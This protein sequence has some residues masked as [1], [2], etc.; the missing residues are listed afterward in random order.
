MHAAL[1]LGVEPR[2]ISAIAAGAALPPG[3]RSTGARDAGPDA[4][5]TLMD[6]LRAG[7][8]HVPVAVTFPL[9]RIRDA[10]TAQA[11]RHVH[12]KIVVTTG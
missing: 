1:A 8:L 10:V 2:R 12:G 11:A 4:M 9:E 5:G 3:V 6:A 7:R